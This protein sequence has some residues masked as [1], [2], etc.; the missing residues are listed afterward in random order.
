MTLADI[1]FWEGIMD[2]ARG[3]GHLRFV[4][5]PLIAIVL[6]A[7]LGIS[8]AKLGRDPFLMSVLVTGTRRAELAKE[9]FM[10][11]IVPFTIA[12]V[13]DGIL[14]YLALGYV[15]PA[16]AVVVGI[17]L[18]AIP[19]SIARALSNRLYRRRSLHDATRA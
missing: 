19:Y 6:G 7:R 3:R 12:I 4:L 17:V 2:T 14:Q 11:V 16:A 1:G 8:D 18:V 5:Q 10:K 13:L 9:G 15:R